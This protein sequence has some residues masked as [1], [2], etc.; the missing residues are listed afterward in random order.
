MDKNVFFDDKIKEVKEA[1][2]TFLN[3]FMTLVF[4]VPLIFVFIVSL[5]SK[6]IY[7]ILYLFILVIP[8]IIC[9]YRFSIKRVVQNYKV[10]KYGKIIKARVAGYCDDEYTIY[11][12][13]AQ[14]IKLLCKV[15]NED[16]MIYYQTGYNYKEYKINDEIEIYVYNDI[17]LIKDEKKNKRDKLFKLIIIIMFI[18]LI[19]YFIIT[20][21]VT[22]ILNTTFYDLEMELIKNNNKEIMTSINGIEYKVPDDYKLSEYH[23][24]YNYKFKSKTN[25]HFCSIDIH[26]E[27]NDESRKII[28]TCS[29]YDINNKYVEDEEKIINGSTWC[30]RKEI[31]YNDIKE[32]YYYSDGK[33]YYSVNLYTYEDKDEKCSIDF[34]NFVKS[35]KVK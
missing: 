8:A 27:D 3:T 10:R 28:D 1:N 29:Y 17:Y 13:S 15:D 35:L 11:G 18:P 22:F 33:K 30:Y 5:S 34:D 24:N 4:T 23:K 26:S 16:K 9:T 2:L 32:E 31:I 14:I 19:I 20:I 21:I 7:N 25:T 12:K 6:D